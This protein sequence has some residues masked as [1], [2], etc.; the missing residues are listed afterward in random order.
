[1]DPIPEKNLQLQA[2]NDSPPGLVQQMPTLLCSGT[3]QQQLPDPPIPN[4][5]PMHAL[6]RQGTQQHRRLPKRQRKHGGL[7]MYDVHDSI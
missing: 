6:P 7:G 4:Q 3:L 1:M 5:R 2:G